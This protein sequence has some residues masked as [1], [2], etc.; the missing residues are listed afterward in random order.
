[1]RKYPNYLSG[2]TT[3]WFLVDEFASW[4]FDTRHHWTGFVEI[5]QFDLIMY[6]TLLCESRIKEDDVEAKY[7][8]LAEEAE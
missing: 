8:E 2:D 7:E 4:L 6:E 5:D 3:Y 1:M